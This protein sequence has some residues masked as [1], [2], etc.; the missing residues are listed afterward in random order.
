MLITPLMGVCSLSCP[1]GT[2]QIGGINAD[3][4]GCGLE[5][6]NARYTIA[7]IDDCKNKCHSRPDCES[8]SWAPTNGD[9][10]HPG[11]KV[12][13][14]YNSASMNQYWGPNQILCSIPPLTCPSGTTQVGNINADIY[15]CGPDGCDGRYDTVD[16]DAWR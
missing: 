2:R 16:I 4:G 13:T 5:A 11:K 9:R 15:G 6:C 1:H 7:N 12:C 10:L 3:I 14:L 8:F